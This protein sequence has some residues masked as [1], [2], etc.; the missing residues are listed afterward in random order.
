MQAGVWRLG[1]CEP[2]GTSRL[3]QDNMLWLEGMCC[4]YDAASDI[5]QTCRTLS[6]MLNK[7]DACTMYHTVHILLHSHH[8]HTGTRIQA[9]Q[10][11]S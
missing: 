2:I 7:L 9:M 4:V 8:L 1:F 10:T 11:K 5:E 6:V 3:K